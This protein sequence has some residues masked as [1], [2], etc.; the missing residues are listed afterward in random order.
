MAQNNQ[1]NDNRKRNRPPGPGKAMPPKFSRGVMGWLV[2]V[3]LAA[4]LIAILFNSQ[5]ERQTWTIPQFLKAK[6]AG[7]IDQEVVI[8]D[9][10]IQGQVR[11]PE[12]KTINFE[13]KLSPG[14]S[15]DWNFHKELLGGKYPLTYRV[16]T[17]GIF[18]Q[19]MISM[20]PWL[21]IF[22]VI[23]FLVFRQMRGAAG[24]GGILGSFGRSRHRVVAKE[25]TNITFQDVAGIE[26]AKDEVTELIE[27][28]KN[29]AKFQRL[30]GRIPRGVLLIG[31]PGTGK[32]L[33]A[34]AIAGEADA[35]FMHISGS[36][37]VEMFVGV[38]AS[39][40]RDLFKQ[41]KD[42]SPCIIFLDEIDA[43]GRRR[44]VG[45]NGGGH[46]EREQ[47]LNAILVE[48]DGFDSNDQVIVIAATNRADVLDPAL[49]R[50]GRFDRQVYI[51]L[52][53]IKGR[54]EILKVHARKIKLSP[55][56]DLARLARGT[57]MLSG[58]DLAAIINEAAIGAT[59]SGKD[60]VELS[61]LEEARD[62]IHWGR[63]RK[64][65]V[66]DESE[67]AITSYHEAGHA[68]IT[69]LLPDAEPLHKVS[70]IPRGQALG[71]TF[72]LPKQDRH[73]WTRKR[74]TSEIQVA[75]AGRAAEEIF[76]DDIS[77]GAAEDIRKATHLARW[78]VCEWGMSEKAGLVRY[79]GEPAVSPWGDMQGPREHSDHTASL[80]D[81]EMKDLLD[82][83][84]T[85]AS[86]ILK[87][88]RDQLEQ[89]AQALLKYETLDVADVE[90]ILKGESLEKPTVADLIEKES[91]KT[92]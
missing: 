46:D 8:K 15:A 69:H 68:L 55:D 67:K 86:Q 62:K 56:A 90:K 11:S 78:M 26:E 31:A 63:A 6:E 38:G 73:L 1:K 19:I 17:A 32:T 85:Q 24:G 71:A 45:Y 57:G 30:G 39:R 29:P 66:I 25:R 42:A 89:L 48:M 84:Y 80:I 51:P 61:D 91:E 28:L 35:P 33:L 65:Q 3:M 54:L 44:G 79:A 27:F 58:A 14:M 60:A 83:C 77:S 88:H 92:D 37:F 40:V 34:R 59:M 41:A 4:L 16:E 43:V 49:T 18:L 21:L 7:Q 53:D 74:T 2:G 76:C 52:P 72:Q 64:S 70:I 5:W 13:V 10:A 75:L 82:G 9:D 23:W 47:T 22:G 12:G 87:A 20:L 36:D 81:Q 50:P